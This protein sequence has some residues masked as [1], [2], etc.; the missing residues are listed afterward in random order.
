MLPVVP[1]FHVNAWG[2]PYAAA[3]TGAKL[4]LP[5]PA[6]GRQVLYELFEPRGHLVGRRAHG[7]A[8]P[9]GTCAGQGPEASTIKRT[10]IGGSACPPAMIRAF[11]GRVRRAP[12]CM[13]GA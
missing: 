4:V 1:M 10:V 2:L 5:R 9:A 13:P 6:A 8:G 3:M 7:L 11:D 12:C